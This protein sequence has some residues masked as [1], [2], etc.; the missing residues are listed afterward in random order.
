MSIFIIY[1][2]FF[3]DA[4]TFWKNVNSILKKKNIS[5]ELLCEDLNISI[6]TLRGAIS[7]KI[8]PRVDMAKKIADYLDTSVDFLLTGEEKNKYKQRLEDLKKAMSNLIEE[9]GK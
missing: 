2:D 4:E 5:Q 6:W 1:K 3:M 9:E 7:K 8:L